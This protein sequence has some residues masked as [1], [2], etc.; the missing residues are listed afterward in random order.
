MILEICTSGFDPQDVHNIRICSGFDPQDVH[1]IRF[2]PQC[3]QHLDMILKIYRYSR[4]TQHLDMILKIYTSGYD[5]Q[6]VHIWI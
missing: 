2:D 5:P 6:D 3:I 1:N 4:Y